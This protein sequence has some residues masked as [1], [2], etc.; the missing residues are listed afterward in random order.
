MIENDRSNREIEFTGDGSKKKKN[1]ES[2]PELMTY[3]QN[4]H[5]TPSI[6]RKNSK[7]KLDKGKG[8]KYFSRRGMRIN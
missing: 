1:T 3:A 6:A 2:E 4:D 5:F 7:K 8:L